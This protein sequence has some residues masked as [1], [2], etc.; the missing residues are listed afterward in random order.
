MR[1]HLP[2]CHVPSFIIVSFFFHI[3]TNT[4]FVHATSK[5][6]HLSNLVFESK[7]DNVPYFHRVSDI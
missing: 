3:L 4:K 7:F 6:Y 1:H 5:F 2:Y